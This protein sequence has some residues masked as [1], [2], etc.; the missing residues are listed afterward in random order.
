MMLASR[1]SLLS[2]RATAL[3]GCV[4][5]RRSAIPQPKRAQTMSISSPM[6][7]S[8]SVGPRRPRHHHLHSISSSVAVASS[9]SAAAGAPSNGNDDKDVLSQALLKP[10]YLAQAFLLSLGAAAMVAAPTK[11]CE[12]ALLS[13][14]LPPPQTAIQLAGAALA[15]P[16]AAS[17]AL[18]RAAAVG[19]RRLSSATYVTL[20]AGLGLFGLAAAAAA[21]T[22]VGGGGV[23][24]GGVT[25]AAAAAASSSLIAPA[26]AYSSLLL[27]GPL[28]LA[29]TCSTAATVR[30]KEEE[31]TFFGLRSR[32]FRFEMEESLLLAST[33]PQLPAHRACCCSEEASKGRSV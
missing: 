31:L 23:G 10:S 11:F 13:C 18:A 28:A 6:V 5:A 20:N 15:L 19:P 27:V 12:L 22:A 8:R 26:R 21:S 2:T 16:C 30:I 9:S 25:A 24:V 1:N 29:V 3:S 14:P 17:L 32:S 7:P 4:A 33:L